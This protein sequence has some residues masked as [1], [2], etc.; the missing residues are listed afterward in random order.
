MPEQRAIVGN[1]APYLRLLREHQIFG[2]VPDQALK[3]LVIRSD[4]LAFLPGELLLRQN[5]ASDSALLII[6]G[7]VEV[8]VETA[9][10][11]VTL[12]TVAAGAL[13]G[14]IGVFAEL[15]RTASARARG[16]VEALRMGRDDM[17]EIGGENLAF[18]RAVMRHLGE[19]IAAFNQA[20][21]FYTDALARLEHQELDPKTLD[22]EP[23]PMPELVD[24]A[25]TFRRMVERIGL[26]R[27]TTTK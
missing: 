11:P 20:M 15:P 21:G 4:L 6:E 12:G 1:V 22:D 18:L 19:R 17:L 10:G 2:Q 13:L 23:Q 9:H 8:L 14:E 3:S 7:E 5:E 25:Y 24:F 27:P 16:A 26:R